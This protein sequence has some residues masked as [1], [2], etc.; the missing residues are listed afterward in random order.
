MEYLEYTAA[1]EYFDDM[2][3]AQLMAEQN[4]EEIARRIVEHFRY[5]VKDKIES[6]HNYIDFS[7]RIIRKG[8]ISAKKDE[9][10][11]IPWNMRDGLIIGRG[12]GNPDW[13]FSAPHGA[14]RV[15]SRSQAKKEVPLDLFKE[16]MKDV[17]ST[18]VGEGTLDE[19]PF[20]YKNHEEI[21][22][23]LGETITIM[24]RVK[25]LYNFK[26]S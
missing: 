7:S 8:A 24:H 4:R 26:A 23:Y 21:E 1:E 25:P 3:V 22:K 18:S 9:M 19:S 5:D 13:N 16:S 2:K 17:Y 20:A 6:V 10:V 12:K 14:G 15:M 11:I